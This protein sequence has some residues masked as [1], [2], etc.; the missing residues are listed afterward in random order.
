MKTI[1]ISSLTREFFRVPVAATE[2]GVQVDPTADTVEFAFETTK[3]AEPAA[4][5]AGSWETDATGP[6]PVYFGRIE[7]G[8]APAAFPLVDGEYWAWIKITDAP[9]I[10]I[11]QVAKVVVT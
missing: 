7:V 11:R 4:W 2:N 3:A 1:Q 8:L 10:P 9:E 6:D 5:V